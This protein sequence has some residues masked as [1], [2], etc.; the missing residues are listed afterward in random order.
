M[1]ITLSAISKREDYLEFLKED[2]NAALLICAILENLCINTQYY[3][4][5]A[6]FGTFKAKIFI[7]CIF[8]LLWSSEKDKVDFLEHAQEYSS[9]LIDVCE[10]QKS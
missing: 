9:L 4:Y 3:Q 6:W 8:P 7:E 1:V 10:E 2:K 5:S